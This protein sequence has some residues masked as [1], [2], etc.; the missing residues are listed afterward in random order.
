[1]KQNK[2]I[3]KYKN[4]DTYGI[5]F[6][7]GTRI[8]DN[9]SDEPFDLEWPVSIDLNISNYC[10]K[11]CSFCYQNCTRKGKSADLNKI[12]KLLHPFMEVAINI[13][14]GYDINN[15][16][17]TDFLGY[18]RDNNIVVN[19]TI[20]QED[21]FSTYP[22]VGYNTTLRKIDDCVRLQSSGLLNGL[23]VSFTNIKTIDKISEPL[24]NIVIHVIAGIIDTKDLDILVK[25]GY[26]I[27]ILGYKQK[28]R[29]EHNELPDMTSLKEWLK[30]NL[31]KNESALCFDNL[32][33]KQLGIKEL[34][35]QQQW[36]DFY[37]GDEGTI[38]MYVNGVDMTFACNSFTK[39]NHNIGD[40][41]IQEMFDIVRREAKHN[42]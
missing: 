13:N 34:I 1:M 6:S 10:E 4:G 11:G 41:N 14:M 8:L 12:K 17:F 9:R 26:N 2:I 38:S 3:Q 40:Y 25:K 22:L 39:D 32:A 23:G 37:Q 30:D 28:G 31:G 5:L 42:G 20:N 33:I 15:K 16:E 18:C 29:A 7:D 27:L 24:K 36:E 35:T 19:A 21:L